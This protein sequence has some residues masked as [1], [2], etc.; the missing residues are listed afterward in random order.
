MEEHIDDFISAMSPC[1]NLYV[2]LHSSKRS[3]PDIF[4]DSL[5]NKILTAIMGGHSR[6]WRVVGITRNALQHYVESNFTHQ[7]PGNGIQRGH[8]VPRIQTTKRVMATESP[9]PLEELAR[10]WFD[11]DARVLCA[12]GEN[13]AIY[14]D[15]YIRFDNPRGDLFSGK[16]VGLWHE[17]EFLRSLASS[18][19]MC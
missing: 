8:I 2:A 9:L 17:E 11:V 1:Y 13:K 18:N 10:L 7:Q 19:G 5:S 15:D 12:R 6:G 14:T 16:L 4:T 3:H